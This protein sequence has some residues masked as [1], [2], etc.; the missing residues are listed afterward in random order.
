MLME[1][2]RRVAPVAASPRPGTDPLVLECGGEYLY[3]TYHA[4]RGE[5]P[6]GP[7]V[8]VLVLEQLGPHRMNL[9]LSRALAAAGY[10]VL[11]VDFRGRGESTGAGDPRGERHHV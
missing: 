11:A 10:P 8:A 3:A 2:E 5:P 6:L 9:R 4:A 1:H 7:R